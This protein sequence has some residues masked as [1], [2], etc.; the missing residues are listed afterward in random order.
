[1]P[2][3]CWQ[4]L[5]THQKAERPSIAVLPFDN[6]SS[7]P[8]QEFLADGIVEDVIAG[9]SRFRSLFVINRGSTFAYKGQTARAADVARDLGV[10]YV[11]E[12][13]LRGA[14]DVIRVSFQLADASTCPVCG[15][16]RWTGD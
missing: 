2:F 5:A 13:S 14:G 7:D 16:W 12:G 4:G 10:R 11:V 3:T 6:M 8:D 9:L 1:M 15:A